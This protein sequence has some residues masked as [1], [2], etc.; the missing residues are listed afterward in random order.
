[1]SDYPEALDEA[2]RKHAVMF[3]WSG[4]LSVAQR[5]MFA[6]GFLA[7]SKYRDDTCRNCR[8]GSGEGIYSCVV[9]DGTGVEVAHE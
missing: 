4:G 2:L 5:A 1:M 8:G 9:C 6:A 7:G 3:D